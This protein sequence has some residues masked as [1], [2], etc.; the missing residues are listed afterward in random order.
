M[1]SS[2]LFSVTEY[3]HKRETLSPVYQ[4]L[5]MCLH[6]ASRF[7]AALSYARDAYVHVSAKETTY[8][9]WWYAGAIWRASDVPRIGGAQ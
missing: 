5:E 1:V 8:Q 3:A 6:D 9:E 7:A 4:S 2:A